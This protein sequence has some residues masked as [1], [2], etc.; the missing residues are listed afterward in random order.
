LQPFSNS[1]SS[2]FEIVIVIA[3]LRKHGQDHRYTEG[4][5]LSPKLT[6]RH[7]IGSAGQC[8]IARESN[9]I[10]ARAMTRGAKPL[11]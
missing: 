4:R 1:S 7:R 9:V 11:A 2:S 3:P 5:T 8:A 6:I 10:G